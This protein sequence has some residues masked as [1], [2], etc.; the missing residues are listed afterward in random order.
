MEAAYTRVV[1]TGYREMPA[2]QYAEWLQALQAERTKRPA[3]S[4]R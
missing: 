2:K 3:T 1:D 4:T